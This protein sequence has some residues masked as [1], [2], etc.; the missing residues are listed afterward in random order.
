MGSP[1]T[2]AGRNQDESQVEVTLTSGFWMGKFEVTQAEWK[3]VSYLSF[4]DLAK[5]ANGSH[6]FGVGNPFPIY[7]VE[8]ESCRKFCRDWTTRERQ[9]GSLPKE[10]LYRLPT[11]AEWEYACRAGTTTATSFGD[12][13]GAWNSNLKANFAGSRSGSGSTLKATIRVGS[14]DANRWGLH[15][16]HGNV[17]EWCADSYGKELPGGRDPFVD[18]RNSSQQRVIR[19]GAWNT[20][21]ATCRSAARGS[22]EPK[23]RDST[24]GFRVVLVRELK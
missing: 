20:D 22:V 9:A 8:H 5:S 2:E 1:A 6:L 10:Y 24:I 4:G 13:L 12:T 17:W 7:Y 21:R 19:G 16:L 23:L 18:A 14:F 3:N 15:D 11:E